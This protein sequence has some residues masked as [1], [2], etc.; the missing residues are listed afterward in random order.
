MPRNPE[1]EMHDCFLQ[2]GKVLSC[3]PA[4]A[5]AGMFLFSYTRILNACE[6]PAILNAYHLNQGDN[7]NTSNLT[8]HAE[9]NLLQNAFIVPFFRYGY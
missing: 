4:L 6:R 7:R 9:T 2:V 5:S 3:F 8:Y 1:T